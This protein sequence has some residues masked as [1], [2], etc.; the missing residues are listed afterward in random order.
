MI[1]W[2]SLEDRRFI[3]SCLSEVCNSSSLL[4]FLI[5]SV[6][7]N[8]ISNVR[9]M[10]SGLPTWFLTF[11]AICSTDRLIS[12]SIIRTRLDGKEKKRKRKGKD[13][14]GV[15]IPPTLSYFIQLLTISFNAQRILLISSEI[16]RY[17]N[18]FYI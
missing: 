10:A 17:L 18:L 11:R 4:A 3:K 9:T 13:C 6:K 15:L 7:L 12:Q 5:S 8:A 16:Q 1:P 2:V 14:P